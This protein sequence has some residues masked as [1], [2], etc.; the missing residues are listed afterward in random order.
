MNNTHR[1][2]EEL[3]CQAENLLIESEELHEEAELLARQAEELLNQV[4]Q[5]KSKRKRIDTF[6]SLA[7]KILK[8]SNERL[9]GFALQTL[10][11]A[12]DGRDL[13]AEQTSRFKLLAREYLLEVV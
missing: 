8:A 7:K 5:L 6:E 10:Y 3:E 1:R 2:I 12:V 11:D 13:D 4:E 9:G